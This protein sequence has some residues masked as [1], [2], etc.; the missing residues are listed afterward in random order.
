MNALDGVLGDNYG[1]CDGG[2][3]VFKGLAK[4]TYQIRVV[5]TTGSHPEN[6]LMR[7]FAETS[8]I[9]LSPAK[10]NTYVYDY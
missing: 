8:A 9:A 10:G 1:F 3:L 6:L 4:G 7:T 5:N 2:A